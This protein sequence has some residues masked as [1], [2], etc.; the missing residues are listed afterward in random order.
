MAKKS[1]VLSVRITE[2]L[3]KMLVA[4]AERYN[5][6]ESQLVSAV[7]TSF[8]DQ[9]SALLVDENKADSI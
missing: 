7:L 9:Y 5:I 2:D 3:K 8:V 4:I 6:E 1:I